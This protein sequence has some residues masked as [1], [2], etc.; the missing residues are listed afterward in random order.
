MNMTNCF[1][2]EWSIAVTGYKYWR[3]KESFLLEG[4]TY[5]DSTMFAIEDGSFQFE[6]GAHQGE[7]KFGDVVVCP[8]GT[9]FKRWMKQPLTFHYVTFRWVVAADSETPI[10]FPEGKVT[11]AD[12]K[13]LSTTYQYFRLSSHN[14]GILSHYIKDLW[15]QHA[16]ETNAYGEADPQPTEDT[17]MHWAI[18]HIR[19]NA[20]QTIHFGSMAEQLE[21][22][23]VQFTRRFRS[24]FGR[25]PSDYVTELRLRKAC[26]LLE[27]TT[28]SLEQIAGQC[29]YENGFYLS[30]IF[31]MKKAVSPSQYRKAHQV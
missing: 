12:T 28:L 16:L 1:S 15:H 31:T 17:L 23:P 10:A 26:K 20:Y 21:M 2:T 8:P 19:D 24:A 7:A 27:E 13:R 6:I 22:T 30:R 4:D 18:R 14:H 3:K 5:A 25:T 29:G 11:I 9:M